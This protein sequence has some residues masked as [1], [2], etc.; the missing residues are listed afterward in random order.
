MLPDVFPQWW[1]TVPFVLSDIEPTALRRESAGADSTTIRLARAPNETEGQGAQQ[2][3][4]RG[5]AER[6][7]QGYGRSKGG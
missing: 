2:A 6:Q 4:D 3:P 1:G 7:K 5:Y